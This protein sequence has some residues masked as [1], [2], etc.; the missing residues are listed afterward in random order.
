MMILL[1]YFSLHDWHS[2]PG[3]GDP[4]RKGEGEGYGYNI[5]VHLNCGA[6]DSDLRESLVENYSQQ[7]RRSNLISF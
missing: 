3:T 6:T 7:P 1:C 2:Y 5:N 4:A